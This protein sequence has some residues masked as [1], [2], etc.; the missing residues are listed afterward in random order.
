MTEY[1]R[2]VDGSGMYENILL[3][4][5]QVRRS[6]TAGYETGAATTAPTPRTLVWAG[7]G[8]S[9]IG[10][11]FVA[12]MTRDHASFPIL[13]H[14]GGR[15][16][17]W[18]GPE[19][20]ALLVSFSGNTAETLDAAEES[21]KREVALDLLTSGG[22]LEQWGGEQN[23]P[24]LKVPGG[25]PPRAALG[26]LFAASLGLLAGRGWAP[27]TR[28][29]IE[30]TVSALNSINDANNG[31]PGD[32]KHP[33]A[34]FLDLFADRLPMIYGTGSM[35]P[36]ARRWANQLNENAKRPA[37]WGELPEM[38]HNEVVAYLE[39]TPWG[40]RSGLVFL[41]DPESPADVLKRVDIT[42]NLAEKAGWKGEILHA[43]GKSPV[44]RLLTTTLL[45]DW[46]SYWAAI[47]AGVDP[48]PIPTID[49][50]KAALDA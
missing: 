10:G 32:A 33:C 27:V 19:D 3:W 46:V 38:N 35:V 42:L 17:H 31:A 37:H 6:F 5:E 14:R 48:T 16:P 21:R 18:V 49:A 45:G 12:A 1:N 24:V 9:A 43:K 15:L 8:G 34:P 30:D 23:L 39:G 50:L 40:E 4:P 29:H 28:D 25:R 44:E 26:D 47:G 13:V 11:D 7:M 41:V 20:R 22:R 36:V 2:S